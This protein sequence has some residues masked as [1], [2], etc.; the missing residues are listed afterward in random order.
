MVRITLIVILLWSSLSWGTVE[1]LS[2]GGGIYTEVD[3]GTELSIYSTN[4]W[5]GWLEGNDAVGLYRSLSST[6]TFT[7]YFETV[8]W[9]KTS[10]LCPE[11]GVWALTN[12]SRYTEAAVDAANDGISIQWDYISGWRL[13]LHEWDGDVSDT[14]DVLTE[15]AWY[16]LKV[17]GNGTTCT[18][19]IYTS[20]ANRT[21]DSTTIDPIYV[22]FASSGDTYDTFCACMGEASSST[23]TITTYSQDY[24]LDI[25]GGEPPAGSVPDRGIGSGIGRGIGG[26]F[27]NWGFPGQNTMWLSSQE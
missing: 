1:D 20:E 3:P 4:E 2:S 27:A 10:S 19:N 7:H 23:E 15:Q 13:V 11:M 6:T 5:G 9:S 14:S 17:V 25:G 21:A 26:G 24:E 16:Y 8:G 22:S 12:S 18:V